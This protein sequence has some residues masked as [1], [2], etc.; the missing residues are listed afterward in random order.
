MA[1]GGGRGHPQSKADPERK[2]P[3]NFP[4]PNRNAP[5]RSFER[6]NS[7]ESDARRVLRHVRLEPVPAIVCAYQDLPA[8]GV[9]DGVEA[10][11][12]AE[13]AAAVADDEA[14][15][16]AP[17]EAGLA[18]RVLGG[19]VEVLVEVAVDAPAPA[20]GLHAESPISLARS[21]SRAL[22]LPLAARVLLQRFVFV[23]QG[24][25]E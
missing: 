25:R 6:R 24:R 13:A 16:A 3:G 23:K 14:D 20:G 18:G 1:S 9:V 22:R 7:T 4:S 21:P 10:G 8:P 2:F 12:H 11:E 19:D 15:G 5:P 17:A